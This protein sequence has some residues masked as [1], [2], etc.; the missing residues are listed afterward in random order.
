LR[1]E[2]NF[3]DEL[4][5][6]REAK[7][8]S[9]AA[10]SRRVNFSKGHLSNVERG[11]RKATDSLAALCDDVLGA[12]GDLVRSF[13]RGATVE[14]ELLRPG[15]N[16]GPASDNAP[17]RPAQLPPGIVDFV[18]RAHLL[19]RLDRL[20]DD[21]GEPSGAPVIALL[22]G[23]AAMGKTALA[24]HWAHRVM[25][26]FP[27]GALFADLHGYGD[28]GRAAEPGVVLDF[29][30]HSLGVEAAGIPEALEARAA[31][32]RSQVAGRRMLIFLDNAASAEQVR[33]LLPAAAGC[34]VLITSR[35]RLAGLSV[36]HA[37]R[38]VDVGPL[39]PQDSAELLGRVI[40]AERLREHPDAV[41][42]IAGYC[43]H[44]PLALRIAAFRIVSLPGIHLCALLEELKSERDRLTALDAGD[45]ETAVRIALSCSYRALPAPAARLFGALGLHPGGPL[46]TGLIGAL[47]GESPPD[48]QA[49]LRRLT[50][51]HLVEELGPDR[52]RMQDLLRLYASECASATITS[53]DQRRAVQR[54][55]DWY[56]HT[57]GAAVVAAPSDGR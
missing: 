4:R 21:A 9:L 27:D 8:V 43:G 34:L 56:L 17:I 42:Q 20:V 55:S 12:G 29:F 3:G 1:A 37:A 11:T 35:S 49:Q 22:V 54:M 10:L 47:Y 52:Y 30:L 53:A 24:L 31:Y 26:R 51:L 16:D 7:G 6:A 23:G 39:T 38:R 14:D 44:Q 48:T 46:T 33:A 50:D 13:R 32:F 19:Q 5:R 18:G 45:Q 36:L 28:D 57:A 40:G 25:S 41:A 15:G 2:S